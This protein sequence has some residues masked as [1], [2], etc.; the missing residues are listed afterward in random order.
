MRTIAFAIA[1]LSAAAMVASAPLGNA[2]PPSFPDLSRYTPVNPQ[3]YSIELANPG[4]PDPQSQIYF[5][6]PDGIT[7]TF[8]NTAVR[9]TGNNFPAVPPAADDGSVNRIGTDIGLK[10][11]RNPIKQDPSHPFKTLP[12]LHS[13]TV[14]GVACGVDDKQTTA[15]KDAQGRGFVLSPSWSGWLPHV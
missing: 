14:S 13:I 7:C 5:L 1:G 11:T 10:T 12:P 4:R 9:C 3:D 8:I 6:T 15:C 2:D